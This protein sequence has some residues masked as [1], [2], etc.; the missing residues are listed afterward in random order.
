MTPLATIL[1]RQIATTGPVSVADFMAECLMNPG[2]GYYATCDPFGTAGD[3]TTAPEISQMFG[4]LLG[5]ALAQAWLDQ[6][7]PAPFTLAELGPG[8]GTLMAD[9]L[10]ATKNVP[11]FHAALQVH[12]VEVSPVL[13][14]AQAK[15]LT[16]YTIH[17]HDHV[18]TLPD[19]PLFLVANEFFDALPI[20]QFQ[21][22]GTGWRERQI[23]LEDDRLTFGLT[24]PLHVRDIEH[25]LDDTRD[26]DLVELC[27]AAPAI[28]AQ[29]ATRIEAHGGAA[30]II[31]YGD[32]RSV[33]D[34]L[35][36]VASHEHVDP[37]ANPGAA[38]LTAHVDFEALVRDAAPLSP[39]LLTPQGLFLE[40]LGITQRAHTLAANLTGGAL[41]THINAHRRLTHPDEMGTL[42]KVLGLTRADA[43]D[44]PGLTRKPNQADPA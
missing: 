24:F 29:I 5:L 15:A 38:D 22:D 7:A 20:R 41:D 30:L 2:H 35:Q 21:R 42:F 26:G 1:A 16:P 32:W 18:D 17:H 31:D 43:P 28:M 23:G 27:P 39:H 12:L 3:F 19:A 37:L 34:T 14:D 6:G 8:R 40:R 10:R 9:I 36:A 13:K 33:G 11:S 44:L 4:E 25:R